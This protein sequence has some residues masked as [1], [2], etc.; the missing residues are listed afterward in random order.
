MPRAEDIAEIA[1]LI[2]RQAVY[3]SSSARQTLHKEML[4]TPPGN[5]RVCVAV[6]TALAALLVG[7]VVARASKCRAGEQPPAIV[8]V[9]GRSRLGT[10]GFAKGGQDDE[11]DLVD[12]WSQAL[13]ILIV[14]GMGWSLEKAA[15]NAHRQGGAAASEPG[16]AN[17]A[18]T[19]PNAQEPKDEQ[20]AATDA[21]QEYDRSDLIL[22]QG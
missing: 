13:A 17:D 6:G 7:I 22:S 1:L 12:D 9:L 18:V 21:I 10:L 2:A 4:S 3:G 20:P 14:L 5:R 15:S 11:Q 8:G 19:L 16:K